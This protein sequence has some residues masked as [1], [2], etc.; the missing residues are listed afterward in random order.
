[1][2]E[3]NAYWRKTRWLTIS[4]F[5]LWL[6]VTFVMNWYAR[7]INE[8]SFLGFPLGF[9]MGAQGILFIYLAI[10]WFYN[11]R[12]RTLDAEYGIKNE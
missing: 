1:M 10:I 2:P 9:Y 11:R 8:I 7:E 12:M 5:V 3:T 6:L 4:L